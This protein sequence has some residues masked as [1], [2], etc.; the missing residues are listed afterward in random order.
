MVNTFVTCSNYDECAKHLDRQ[1]LG[2]QRVEAKQILDILQDLH[3]IAEK[4]NSHF[5]NN[6]FN[7]PHNEDI[8]R[9]FLDRCDWVDL[10]RNTYTNQYPYIWLQHRSTRKI[11]HIKR[12]DKSK[13]D[14]QTYRVVL[15]GF[16]GHPA[17][18]M[19]CGHEQSLKHYINACI[20]EWIAR[21]YQNNMER[22]TSSSL[23]PFLV[24]DQPWWTKCPLFH[25]NH[26]VAL[27]RKEYE[28]S[29]PT[30]YWKNKSFTKHVTSDMYNYGYIW[31]S[32]LKY[33]H[34]DAIIKQSKCLFAESI[35]LY[36]LAKRVIFP[37]IVFEQ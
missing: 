11:V 14:K 7:F 32:H 24:N 13:I 3:F 4:L 17:V 8:A 29:E 26:I 31:P 35:P 27:L 16:S 5:Q 21:G 19:W 30:W 28:R 36:K 12:A 23:F 9:M 20:D 15:G 34:I 18:K 37:E 25:Q 1:R 2:K 22:Y 10:V 6:K 33:K